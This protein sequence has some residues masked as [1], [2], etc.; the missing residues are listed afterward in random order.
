VG[1]A[2]G[3]LEA[4]QYVRSADWMRPVGQLLHVVEPATLCTVPAWQA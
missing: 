4:T 2:L 3:V 1:A